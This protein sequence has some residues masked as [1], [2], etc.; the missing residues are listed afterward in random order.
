[1]GHASWLSDKK[2]VLARFIV[3]LPLASILALFFSYIEHK[4]PQASITFAKSILFGVPIPYF[5]SLPFL[6]ADWLHFGFWQ[7]YISA[8]LFL[9]GSCFAH[10]AIMIAIG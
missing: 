4:D 6:L 3:A 1:M 8:L 2:P 5:L 7:S 10:R 9:V